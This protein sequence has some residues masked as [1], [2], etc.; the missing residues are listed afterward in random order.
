M[1]FISHRLEEVFACCQRVTVMRDGRYVRTAPID[2]LTIDD[3][4]RA[5]VGRDLDALFPK[6]PTEPGEVGARGR[7]DLTR[8]GVFRD[9]SFEVR[10][11]RSSRSPASSAR[12]APRWREPIFGI[13]RRTTGEVGRPAGRCRTATPRAAMAAGSRSSPRTAGSRAW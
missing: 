6:S 7:R 11:A 4:I 1:L 3:I 9:I 12:A 13:D 10:A 8:A 5:M 2:E